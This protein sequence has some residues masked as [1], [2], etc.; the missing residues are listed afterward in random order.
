MKLFPKLKILKGHYFCCY[1]FIKEG[2]WLVEKQDGHWSCNL[3]NQWEALFY[4]QFG[5]LGFVGSP[6]PCGL[7][8]THKAQ[9]KSI[10]SDNNAKAISVWEYIFKFLERNNTS[11]KIERHFKIFDS[12]GKILNFDTINLFNN[13]QLLIHTIPYNSLSLIFFNTSYRMYCATLKRAVSMLLEYILVLQDFTGM[14]QDI[15]ESNNFPVSFTG[16]I[17]HWHSSGFTDHLFLLVI[18]W[19]A[20]GYEHT[21]RQR[22]R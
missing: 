22:Q 16:R 15:N 3:V 7:W 14:L 13:H 5:L 8:L 18:W 1:Y 2:L 11:W 17:L 6:R 21:E 19:V 12:L 20:W 4:K 9:W 10:V